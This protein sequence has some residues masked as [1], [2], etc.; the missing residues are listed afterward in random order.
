MAVIFGAFGFVYSGI[1]NVSATEKDPKILTWLLHTT[2]KKSVERRARNINVP[3]LMN[4][5]MIL[6]GLADYVGMCAQCHGEPGQKP[7]VLAQG[8]NPPPPDLDHLAESGTAAEIFWIIRNGIRMTGMPS[9]GKTHEEKEIWPV[10]AFLESAGNITEED[11]RRM[12]TEAIKYGHHIDESS[13][14]F[15]EQGLIDS[16]GFSNELD[17]EQPEEKHNDSLEVFTDGDRHGHN[18]G[19]HVH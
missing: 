1:L 10:V 14:G 16:D 4:R 7:G 8:M 11:Y 5:E 2:M 12:K 19:N 13:M 3:D 6:A 9:F 18:N 17:P 15:S